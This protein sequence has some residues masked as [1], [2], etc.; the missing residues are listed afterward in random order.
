MS[1]SAARGRRRDACSRA[2]L[3]GGALVTG[4]VTRVPGLR[5]RERARAREQLRRM[6]PLAPSQEPILTL[7]FQGPVTDGE[8]CQV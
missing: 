4:L 8:S 7:R 5:A 6:Y 3:D 2:Q 1:L